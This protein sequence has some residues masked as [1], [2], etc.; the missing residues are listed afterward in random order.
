MSMYV[1]PTSGSKRKTALI[2]C[3]FLGMFGFHYFYV[4][5]IGKGIFYLFTFGFFLFG[6]FFD[7]F[8][9]LLGDFRDK[10]GFYLKEW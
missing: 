8:K 9:I 7:I 4:G 5:R 1:T 6:W 3:I 2:L 10:Y